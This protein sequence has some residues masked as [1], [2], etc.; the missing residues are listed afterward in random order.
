MGGISSTRVRNRRSV[1]WRSTSSCWAAA[2]RRALSRAIEATSANRL[3]CW[4]S[5]SENSRP[6]SE[7]A[8]PITPVTVPSTSSGTP[9][10]ARK[11]SVAI[12]GTCPAQV[13]YAGVARG[14]P[15]PPAPPRE[16]LALEHAQPHE[17]AV[18]AD[19]Q[20]QDH[21]AAVRLDQADVAVAGA[22]QLARPGDAP[23]PHA[24]RGQ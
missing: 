22:G 6:G 23:L 12:W 1:R 14:A 8:R 2:Y 11:A 4:T 17:P 10:T 5:S 18:G 16:A 19:P 20:P 9:S 21:L 24:A 3:P 7:K 15:P 13:L